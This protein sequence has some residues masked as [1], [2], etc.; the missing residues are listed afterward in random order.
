MS[1]HQPLAIGIDIGGTG[2]KF[3]TIVFNSSSSGP[4]TVQNFSSVFR[5]SVPNY[6]QVEI[7]TVGITGT[8]FINATLFI[9]ISKY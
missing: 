8:G 7:V 4:T 9:S 5:P 1:A 6:L 3:A 2:T